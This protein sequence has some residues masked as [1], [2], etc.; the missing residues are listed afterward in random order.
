MRKKTI[1]I[2]TCTLVIATVLAPIVGSTNISKL[3]TSSNPEFPLEAEPNYAFSKKGSNLDN[4]GITDS[5]SLG[6]DDLIR[7]Y[8]YQKY[9]ISGSD[10]GNVKISSNGGSSWTSLYEF[11]GK[12]AQWDLNFIDISEYSGKTILIGFQYVTKEESISQGWS[13]DKIVIQQGEVRIYGEEFEEYNNNDPWGDWI[14][15]SDLNPPENYPPYPP[16]IVGPDKG[17]INKPLNFSFHSLDPDLDSVSY[18]IEW[19]D[20]TVT[21]WTEYFPSGSSAYIKDHTWTEE[22]T[23]TIKSKAKDINNDESEWTELTVKI[24][25]GRD[26]QSDCLLFKELIER[27]YKQLIKSFPIF[28]RIIES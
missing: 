2:L 25:K 7:L 18:Y 17:D 19:G 14:I 3:H 24:R 20:D 22:G 15:K 8:Y 5:V 23:Y 12:I 9:D 11:Q 6:S 16:N 13:I 26:R 1:G 28:N 27:L 21:D 10:F 4:W